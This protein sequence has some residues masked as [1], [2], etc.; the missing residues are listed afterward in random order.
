V[1]GTETAMTTL[2]DGDRVRVEGTQGTVEVL[3]R[4]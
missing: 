4:A 2:R 3:A 1:I